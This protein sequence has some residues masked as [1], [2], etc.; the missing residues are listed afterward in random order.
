ME[1]S[2]TAALDIPELNK[3]ASIAHVSLGWKIILYFL[4]GNFAT[5]DTHS[6]S[7]MLRFGHNLKF[8]GASNFERRLRLGHWTL[9][10][11]LD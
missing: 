9:V 5:R 11:K 7:V 1:L 10:N 6:L 4:L 8:S 2:H 3:A